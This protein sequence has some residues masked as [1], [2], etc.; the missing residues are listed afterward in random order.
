MNYLRIGDL[1]ARKS[2]DYDILFKI[3]DI[4]ERPG[5]PSTV[6]LKGVDLRIVADAP[7]EDL[8]KIPLNKLDEFHHSYSKKIDKLVKRILK[9]RNQ[10]YEGYGGLTRTIPEHIRGGIPFG[11]PGKV[12]HLDGDGEYLDVCLKTYK[13]LEIEAVGKQISESDQPRVI[14]D[15]LRE[16]APD[17]LVIT[18]HDAL[19]RGYKDFTNI[20]NYRS[21][22]Y[23]IEAVKEA[24]RYEPNMDDLVIFA[25]ACQSHYEAILSA[26]ANFASSPHRILMEWRM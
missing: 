25:G 26:G 11:K 18:G 20:Q 5:R 6:V 3:V 2:Y 7:E 12:L 9:E 23:F 1:V 10:K 24:R 14:S 4:V 21:S 22:K 19:L 15:L 8:Q 16:H 17:I 13:Q